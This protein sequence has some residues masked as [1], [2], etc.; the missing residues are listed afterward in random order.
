MRID[1]LLGRYEAT[2]IGRHRLVILS[3]YFIALV[4]LLMSNILGISGAFYPFFTISNMVVLVA[5]CILAMGYL[6]RKIDIVTTL[7]LMTLFTQL[8]VSADTLY[9][10]FDPAVPNKYTV[11]I[12]NMLLLAGNTIVALSTYLTRVTQA[13]TI[14][15]LVTYTVCMIETKDSVLVDYYFMLFMVLLF[16]SF[17]GFHIAKNARRLEVENTELRKD[18]ARLLQVLRLNK[19]QVKAYI[20]LASER[21][22]PMQTHNL[23]ELLGETSQKNILAN[24]KEYLRINNTEK[25]HIDECFPELTSSEKAICQLVLRGK[26]LGEICSI[27]GK[28]E[29]NVN[30]QRANIR[31]K[32]GLSTPE[33]LQKALER[34]M[35]KTIDPPA[36]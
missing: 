36:V 31:R 21:H 16:F 1:N 29:S 17:L 26:K 32:L 14:I 15:I 13:H 5:A 25:L 34:R 7:S 23:L 2:Y 3:I 30:T 24:V 10:G 27:L 35:E 4:L 20:C 8:G 6:C 18:E 28:T 9:C 11:I 22:D 19:K 33:S 12:I